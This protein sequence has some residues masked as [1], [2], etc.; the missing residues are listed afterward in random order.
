MATDALGSRAIC[1][2]AKAAFDG[3]GP[4]EMSVQKGEGL[5]IPEQPVSGDGWVL[6]RNTDDDEGLVPLDYLDLHLP[7]VV[8]VLGAPGSGRSTHCASIVTQVGGTYLNATEAMNA[9]V[10]VG[11][12]V[13][14]K[15][16]DVLNQGKAVTHELYAELLKEAMGGSSGPF[17]IDGWPE[18]GPGIEALAATGVKLTAA[19]A[20]EVPSDVRATRISER[21]EVSGWDFFSAEERDASDEELGKRCKA[22]DTRW[23][24][25]STALR[26]SDSLHVITASGRAAG[27]F[28]SITAALSRVEAL[29][30]ARPVRRA[31]PPPPGGSESPTQVRATF[32]QPEATE[33]PVKRVKV[34]PMRRVKEGGTSESSIRQDFAKREADEKRAAKAE[35]QVKKGTYNHK[36]A[37]RREGSIMGHMRRGESLDGREKVVKVESPKRE[38]EKTPPPKRETV[39]RPSKPPAPV[40]DLPRSLSPNRSPPGKRQPPVEPDA[41]AEAK[42]AATAAKLEAKQALRLATEAK[43]AAM[44][45]ASGMA[46]PQT[47]MVSPRAPSSPSPAVSSPRRKQQQAESGTIAELTQRAESAERV[48]ARV[49]NGMNSF[50][51]E[52]R[53]WLEDLSPSRQQS[54][55]GSVMLPEI[56]P[57]LDQKLKRGEGLTLDEQM[58][59]MAAA[60][61]SLPDEQPSDSQGSSAVPSRMSLSRESPR[62]LRSAGGERVSP[63]TLD[64]MDDLEDFTRGSYSSR[65]ASSR[66]ADLNLSHYGGGSSYGVSQSGLPHTAYPHYQPK[67]RVV[68]ARRT[69]SPNR[70]RRIGEGGMDWGRSGGMG[71]QGFLY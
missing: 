20:L 1:A 9:A 70:R 69:V 36:E 41:A 59:L 67:R 48:A 60:R 62:V 29:G 30:V 14:E 40:K 8:C 12:P 49:E 71:S 42:A 34:E 22:Y 3:G 32:K 16:S 46:S 21:S 52:V 58:T 31:P 39:V 4:G 56:L 13:G 66:F 5:R 17:V 37:I 6:A 7:T 57:R 28:S 27:A 23:G 53:S 45:A 25:L 15:V 18:D 10:S 47:S 55:S 19:I 24:T 35:L 64:L 33:K 68:S 26:D 51:A 54:Q 38:R 2:V 11:S 50:M 44:A 63:R 43:N 61:K 65:P